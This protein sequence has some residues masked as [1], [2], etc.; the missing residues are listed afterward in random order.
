MSGPVVKID[1]DVLATLRVAAKA[2]IRVRPKDPNVDQ[3]RGAL[4]K[5]EAIINRCVKCGHEWAQN[6][7]QP[8][9][10]CPCAECRTVKW[11]RVAGSPLGCVKA[12]VAHMVKR[13]KSDDRD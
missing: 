2:F 7:E 3:F 12:L 9:R 6:G 4:E 1:S 10:R 8:P 11:N 5:S 13:S